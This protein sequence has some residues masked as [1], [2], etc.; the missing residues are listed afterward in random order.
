MNNQEIFVQKNRF[1]KKYLSIFVQNERFC[2]LQKN[3]GVFSRFLLLFGKFGKLMANKV[4]F[5]S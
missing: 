2:R 5:Y 4:S 3:Q 1:I